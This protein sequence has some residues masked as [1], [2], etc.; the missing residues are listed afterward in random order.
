MSAVGDAPRLRNEAEK[1][2]HWALRVHL[3]QPDGEPYPVLVAPSLGWAG[4]CA[5]SIARLGGTAL[6]ARSGPVGCPLWVNGLLPGFEPGLNPGGGDLTRPFPPRWVTAG[7]WPTDG[8]F[9][10]RPCPLLLDPFRTAAVTFGQS[11][12]P[13]KG[14]SRFDGMKPLGGLSLSVPMATACAQLP[15]G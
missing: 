4:H 13:P 10:A 5:A 14:R 2:D 3:T 7:A 9:L 8:L 12:V 6:T 15:G 11:F 1:S